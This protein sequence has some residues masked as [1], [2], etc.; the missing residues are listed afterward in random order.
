MRRNITMVL[1]RLLARIDNEGVEDHCELNLVNDIAR[2]V[3]QLQGKVSSDRK[4]GCDKT[5]ETHGSK[6]TLP[7]QACIPYLKV[8]KTMDSDQ[9][10]VLYRRIKLF[11]RDRF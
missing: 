10:K 3:N 6:S 5:K 9:L 11:P 7:R 1:F 4:T 8:F 2:G